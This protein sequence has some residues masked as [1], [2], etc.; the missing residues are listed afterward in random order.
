MLRSQWMWLLARLALLQ[1]RA[2]LLAQ[3]HFVC[4]AGRD[5]VL[6]IGHDAIPA[7]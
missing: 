2:M 1:Q 6:Q 4:S 7:R 5:K 3:Q